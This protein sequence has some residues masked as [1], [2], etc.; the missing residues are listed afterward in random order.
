CAGAPG[1][2]WL[3]AA[4]AVQGLGAAMMSANS[5]ALLVSAFPPEERGR[6]LGAFG[7]AVGVG[8]AAGPPIGGWIVS[9]LSWRWLFLINLPLGVL[10]LFLLRRQVPADRA[11]ENPPRLRFAPA[12]L[13]AAGLASLMVAL[14]LGP[15]RGWS[16]PLVIGSAA[17]AATLGGMFVAIERRSDDPLL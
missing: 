16:A 4:R 15:E 10:A 12:L 5:T 2:A 11:V 13:G 7:A 1:V 17:A 6:A 8:L 3:I 9:A 14:S